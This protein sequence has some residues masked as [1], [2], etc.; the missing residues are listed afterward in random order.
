MSTM[1]TTQAVEILRAH[2]DWRRGGEG[3]V[4]ATELGIAIDTVTDAVPELLAECKRALDVLVD[5]FA[6]EGEG[7]DALR[8]AIAAQ[9]QENNNG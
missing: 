1:T 2:N 5:Q 8:A 6:M 3:A 4:D 9:L 7:I